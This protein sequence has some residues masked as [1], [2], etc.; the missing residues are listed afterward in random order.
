MWK[1]K[2]MRRFDKKHAHHL[3]NASDG[4][5]VTFS[6]WLQLS[7]IRRLFEIARIITRSTEAERAASGFRRLKT[8]Y[9][10]TMTSDREHNSLLKP[11]EVANIFMRKGNNC[12][13]QS[14]PPNS[15][16]N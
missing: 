8:A 13:M 5:V 10:S 1:A 7:N 2:K 3:D 9:R 15:F 16:S 12:L 14:L 6:G 11:M 4:Y